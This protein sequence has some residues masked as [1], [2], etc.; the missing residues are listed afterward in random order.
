M[1]IRNQ[2]AKK[3]YYII[4]EIGV[5]YYDL[6]KKYDVSLVEAAKIMIAEAHSA[7]ADAVKF[8]TYKADTLAV[9]NSPYYWDFDAVPIR[10]QYDLFKNYEFLTRE[11][12]VS[13]KEWCDR[14]GITFLSTPFDLESTD[15]L[16]DLMPMYKISSSDL[17]NLPFVKYI[18]EKKKPIILSVGASDLSE[19]KR[20]VECIKSVNNCQLTLLHCVLEYPTPDYDANLGRIKSLQ[21]EFPNEIIGYSDHTKPTDHMKIVKMAYLLG[22]RVIEKHFTIDKT[23][24]GK[25]DHFHSMDSN[26]LREL[27][28]G[29]DEINTI[30]GDE[31]LG[32]LASEKTA[33]ENA[34]RSLVSTRMIKRGE[35]ITYEMLTAKRPGTGISPSDYDALISKRAKTDIDKDTT[36]KWD[37]FE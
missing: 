14:L 28:A 7:G 23:I 24:Q 16:Y 11:D 36:L 37:M 21:K 5:N 12:Y 4:A 22:A 26:D 17:N 31:K 3:G 13:I 35:V 1:E 29:L 25:N 6:A 8:Q 19:I 2:I 20:S 30:L 10:T 15:Y 33:R 34:R 18:S 27:I 9:K 32:V